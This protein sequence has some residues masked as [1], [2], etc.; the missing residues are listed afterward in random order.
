MP[1]LAEDCR[2]SWTAGTED[3]M[4]TFRKS[5]PAKSVMFAVSYDDGRTGYL[6]VENHGKSS[7]DY[8][9]PSIARERQVRGTLPQGTITSIKRVR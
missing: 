4:Y 6:V 1:S 8:L 3:A 2:R 7:D 5:V 9:V